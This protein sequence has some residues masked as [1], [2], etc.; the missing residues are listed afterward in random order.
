MK[1]INMGILAHVDAGKTTLTEHILH[2]AKVIDKPGSVDKGNTLTDSM[3]L[4]RRRGITIKASA[5][6]FMLKELKVNLLDTPGHADFISEVER[7]LSVLDGAVLVISAV[8]GIQA[9]TKV[10]MNTLMQLRIPTILFIN[11]ID[12]SGADS[13]KVIQSIKEKL[14]DCAIPLYRGTN[15]GT[16]DAAIAKNEWHGDSVLLEACIETLLL[17]DEYMLE[18]Y[19]NGKTFTEK[20]LD[21]AVGNQAKLAKIYPLFVG[22]AAKGIGVK[23]LIHGIETLL[24]ANEG[25]G[26]PAG[27][28]PALSA[29]VFKIEREA[30]GEKRAYIRLFSGAIRAREEVR[31]SR[32][33]RAGELESTADK[34]K[35]LSML[36]NGTIAPAERIEAGDI[37]VV[38]GLKTIKIGDMIG[39]WNDRMRDVRL[40]EP[41]L[42]SVI[43]PDRSEDA[44]KLFE[45]LAYMA[46]EDPFIQVSRGGQNFG[47]EIYIRLYG[48]VQKEVIRT[49][50]LE[51]Y[52]IG[53]HFSE[54]E[55]RCI[56][57]PA[58]KGGA[59]S[60]MGE[61]GNPFCATIGFSVEPAGE[62]CGIVYELAV[63]LGSLPLPFHKAIEDT[64]H[65]T[66]KQGLYGWEV[67]DIKVTLT[68]TGY[69]SPV[70]VAGDFRKLVP[71][72][73]MEAL[74]KAGTE[75]YE[76]MNSFEFNVPVRA[77]SA[78][79]FQ[80]AKKKAVFR[81]PVLKKEE[82]LVTGTIPAAAT[83]AFKSEVQ[84]YTE[85]EG[86]FIAKPC[87]YRKMAE[88][89]PVRKRSDY[90]PLNK[91]EYLMH[92]MQAI[93]KRT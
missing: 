22:A 39:E 14:T 67:A 50:L 63:E 34:I 74:R 82:Y 84:S 11:K 4:E 32:R 77:L 93:R 8:E 85:G 36:M 75:V 44:H 25:N 48:E 92:V 62:N 71:L 18:S 49:I 86:L 41:N 2:E 37:G 24:P 80:L 27:D 7:S 79:L 91:S 59:L 57:K 40:N 55:I 90:N 56:E 53:A 31:I 33:N 70:T 46:E 68:A 60:V 12:R 42:E 45:A 78:A 30:A 87:G 73:L 72:V 6:S 28:C 61:A 23:E 54:T 20:E 51:N 26:G 16:A 47:Q 17:N 15:E 83:E 19:T 81:E 69:A 1:T 10:L 52:G 89:F 5:V 58:G 29:V 64:V 9:Q 88:P 43:K 66:L 35:N 3:E 65:Q 13:A 21:D 38:H 76:P